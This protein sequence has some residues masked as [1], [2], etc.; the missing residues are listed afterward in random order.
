MRPPIGL[1]D[2]G[3][4]M[5]KLSDVEIVERMPAAQG[6]ER[7][8]D[9]LV[10]TWQFP[11]FRRAMEFV[12]QVASQI[13]KADHYPDLTIGYRS[14]RIETSTHDVGGLSER[15]FALIAE[16]NEISTDR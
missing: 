2:Q 10:K 4:P 12:N 1:T 5:L 6:W 15:D 3:V 7:H 9:M 13:E 14:V 11:T 8:G 16:I